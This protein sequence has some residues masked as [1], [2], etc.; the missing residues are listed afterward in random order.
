MDSVWIQSLWNH[1]M[2]PVYHS[3]ILILLK[4]VLVPNILLIPL[5]LLLASGLGFSLSFSTYLFCVNE[6]IF[7]RNNVQEPWNWYLH[8]TEFSF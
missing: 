3:E 6:S 5:S 1:E 2:M 7:R 8:Q 4:F